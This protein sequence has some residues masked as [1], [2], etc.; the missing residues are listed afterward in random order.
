[1][2]EVPILVSALLLAAE[3]LRWV[4]RQVLS[5]SSRQVGVLPISTVPCSIPW[6]EREGLHTQ[7]RIGQN[8]C[9]GVCAGVPG[10]VTR[11][12]V[13]GVLRLGEGRV[14]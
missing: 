1:M 4:D 13:C 7:V 12:W 8:I 6:A 11:K 5:G 3:P 2:S 9:F 10:R 14:S